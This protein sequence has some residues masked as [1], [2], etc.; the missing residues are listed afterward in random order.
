VPLGR[1]TVPQ[2]R[3]TVPRGSS[4][5]DSRIK[6][7]EY[8]KNYSSVTREQADAAFGEFAAADARE[9][10]IMATMDEQITKIRD[11]YSIDLKECAEKKGQFF[12]IIQAY[13]QIIKDR[14]NCALSLFTDELSLLLFR[15]LPTFTK[16][17]LSNQ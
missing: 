2:G 13:T 3:S 14:G 5:N 6:N 1:S 4:S 8:D 11:K 7:G 16:L 15:S 17:F 12:D 9:Q 10:K